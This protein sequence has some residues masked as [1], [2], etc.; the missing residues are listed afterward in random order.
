[1]KSID[2]K[3]IEE[4][5]EK[6]ELERE[7]TTTIMDMINHTKGMVLKDIELILEKSISQKL[8]QNQSVYDGGFLDEYEINKGY[9]KGLYLSRDYIT[10]L[11][12]NKHGE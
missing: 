7:L 9:I 5:Q 6:Q 1:M 2:V 11:L 8:K 10:E 3:S 4:Q 12:I